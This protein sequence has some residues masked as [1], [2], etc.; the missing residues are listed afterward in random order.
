MRGET[1]VSYFNGRVF[2]AMVA[3]F[4]VLGSAAAAAQQDEEKPPRESRPAEPAVPPRPQ[5]FRFSY[6]YN[7]AYPRHIDRDW[8]CA[9][10]WLL[11][12]IRRS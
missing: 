7:F 2:P 4:C 6:T 5:E 8:K 10:A 12:R 1:D 11:E 9:R 3:A